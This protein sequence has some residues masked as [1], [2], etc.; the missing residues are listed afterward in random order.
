MLEFLGML[1][2]MIEEKKILH[3]QLFKLM[4]LTNSPL[5]SPLVSGNM[6]KHKSCVATEFS[7]KYIL[8]PAQ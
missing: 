2:R 8:V 1:T 6:K 7:L 4:V 3:K 5:A